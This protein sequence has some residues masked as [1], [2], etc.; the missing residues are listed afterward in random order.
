[1]SHVKANTAPSSSAWDDRRHLAD[2][3]VQTLD[4]VVKMKILFIGTLNS[5]C[6]T[7]AA[8]ARR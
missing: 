5:R 1:V 7:P 4:R 6:P 3:V 2:H 8:R